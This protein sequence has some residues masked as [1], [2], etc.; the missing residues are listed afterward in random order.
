MNGAAATNAARATPETIARERCM[1]GS[2]GAEVYPTPAPRGRTDRVSLQAPRPTLRLPGPIENVTVETAPGSSVYEA[3]DQPYKY[4]VYGVV[5]TSDVPLAL[6]GYGDGDALARIE[7]VG[8]PAAAFEAAVRDAVFAPTRASW[9]RYVPLRDG[10]TYVRWDAVGEFIVDAA[11]DRI[12]HRRLSGASDESFQVYMLGQALSFALVQQ[13]IEPLHATAIVF[14]EDAV[15]FLGGTGFGKS[16]L[17]AAFLD[18]GCRLLTD[19]LLVLRERA[20]CVVAYPGPPRIKLFAKTALRF[21]AAASART[22]MNPGT[23]KLIVPVEADASCSR[24]VTLRAIYSL[25]APTDACRTAGV[26]ID[27]LSARDAFITLAGGTFNR[28][29]V[30][31]RRLQRQFTAMA[32]IAERVPVKRLSYARAHDRLPA[33]RESIL[34]DLG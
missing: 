13:G 17:A 21:A 18:A 23:A 16:S 33:V 4:G 8:A 1:N 3:V 22:R 29:L 9:Y 6:P 15:A 24:P 2:S 27:C 12:R 5:V 19:D 14:G 10:S 30:N 26:H 20:T 31:A 25:A 34:A 11:G 32:R 28:R 7:C